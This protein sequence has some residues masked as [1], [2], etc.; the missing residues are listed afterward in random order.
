ML[1]AICS[2]TA[3]HLQSQPHHEG[4]STWLRFGQCLA[5][6]DFDKDGRI[7]QAVV[8]GTGSRRNIA[9]L[10]SASGRR[11]Y[12]SFDTHYQVGSIYAQDLDRDG[13]AD[14]IWTDLLHPADAVVWMGNG[15]GKFER[16]RPGSFIAGFL[17]G[18]CSASKPDDSDDETALA[19]PSIR[20]T[21]QLLAGQTTGHFT[22][23]VIHR[24]H[25]GLI[26]SC[27]CERR[28][29]SRGPPFLIS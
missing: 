22:E 14:L 4:T 18:E 29:V 20:S 17:L 8:E 7:D 19:D 11:S 3:R 1:L 12:L 10:L 21:D 24:E 9:V 5:L 23:A 26:A 28:P 13:D 27:S 6:S 2:A 16:A 25:T 15:A